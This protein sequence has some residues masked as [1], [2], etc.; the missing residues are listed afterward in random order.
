MRL[1]FCA[2]Y[3]HTI[4]HS[5]ESGT[6]GILVLRLSSAWISGFGNNISCLLTAVVL[7]QNVKPEKLF[8]KERAVKQLLEI[9]DETT[10]QNNGKFYAWDKSEVPW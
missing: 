1:S 3:F 8:T 10:S 5:F 7:L 9:I 4:V 6:K 2:P